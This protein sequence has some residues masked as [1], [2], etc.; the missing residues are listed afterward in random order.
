MKLTDSVSL[1]LSAVV[2]SLTSWAAEA[3][4]AYR[5][6]A[7]VDPSS[8]NY[9]YPTALNNKGEVIGF[10]ETF[11]N[12]GFHWKNGVFTDLGTA[13][14][15]AAAI[16]S[17]AGINDRST[18]VGTQDVSPRNFR[19]RNGQLTA[20]RISTADGTPSLLSIND[21]DQ[22]LGR[23]QSSVF[24]WE[25][26]TTTFLENLP[27]SDQFAPNAGAINDNGVVVGTNGTENARLA[28]IWKDGSIM[29]LPLLP[30]TDTAEG[31]DINNFD[32]VVGTAYGPGTARPFFWDDGTLT[33]LP[34]AAGGYAAGAE[35]INDWGAVVGTSSVSDRNIATLWIAGKGHDLNTLIDANDPLRGQVLLVQGY[36]INNRGQIV[37]F[38]ASV[39]DGRFQQYLLTPTYRPQPIP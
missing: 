13:T 25:R 22:M 7:I 9:V 27:G 30:G 12:R 23:G 37:A 2:L 14:G 17:P 10:T 15:S 3:Q 1:L 11:G 34:P 19:I 28:V 5:L 33:E 24:I 35:E 29:A 39:S 8:T 21:R 18:I 38:G 26:G 4:L 20:V 32:Q 6:T 36:F 16:M 31:N